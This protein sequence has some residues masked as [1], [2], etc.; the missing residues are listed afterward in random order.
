MI[1][2]KA[3][4]G[5]AL[6]ESL[7]VVRA[8]T[9][10][11]ATAHTG[12]SF[13]SHMD[14]ILAPYVQSV[15]RN[16]QEEQLVEQNVA[17]AMAANAGQKPLA[18]LAAA[19]VKAWGEVGTGVKKDANNPHFNNDYATLEAVLEAGKQIFANNGLALLQAPGLIT[20]GNIEVTGMLIHK[21]GEFVTF[22]TMVP[23]GGKLTAQAGGSA[24]T[25]GRRYQALAV[26]GLAPTDDD[27]EAASQPAPKAAKGNKVAA[28]ADA[29]NYAEARDAL[30]DE[31]ESF[32]GTETE[33]S[34]AIKPRVE[35]LGD[36]EV[37]KAYIAK[38]RALKGKK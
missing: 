1:A 7:G 33:F 22:R 32:A 12:S 20:D 4:L 24:T 6:P 10:A 23:L 5:A 18:N 26:F 19:Y 36:E 14:A 27:G 30:L 16:N 38:R 37:N 25:Y 2:G 35:E 8:T 31:I 17:A 21:S 29:G 28:K 3:P 9:R 11:A 13:Q 34:T 15:N